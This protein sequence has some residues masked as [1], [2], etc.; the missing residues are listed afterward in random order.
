MTQVTA[1]K[2]KEILLGIRSFY[3]ITTEYLQGRL[4]LSNSFMKNVCCLDV[5]QIKCAESE[6]S[7]HYLLSAL[8]Q[9]VT[10]EEVTVAM[11]EWKMLS[12]DNTPNEWDPNDSSTK[13]TSV[14]VCWR[15]NLERRNPLGQLKYATLAKVVKACL[16]FSQGN[17][18]AERSFSVNKR[19][20]TNERSSLINETIIATRL[21]KDGIR[22]HGGS[23]NT[24][25]VNKEMILRTRAS[26]AR[27][28][29]YLSKKKQAAE[30]AE[31]HKAQKEA[32]KRQLEIAINRR[33]RK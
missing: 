7:F 16:V 14:D 3:F 6:Q 28:R 4:P 33:K 2:K 1:A 30:E 10:Q 31:K 8:P 23:A 17:S 13:P 24:V 18:D 20:V 22:Y 9:I 15:L 29:E 11:D 21:V 25:T 19:L 12:L 5:S 26:N 27:Y 32:K